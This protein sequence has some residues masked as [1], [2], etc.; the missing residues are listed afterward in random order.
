VEEV[1]AADA[2]DTAEVGGTAA[3]ARRT[4]LDELLEDVDV[5]V[6][7]LGEVEAVRLV[8][9]SEV[10]LVPSRQKGLE[11]VAYL[12]LRMTPVERDDLAYPW[13]FCDEHKPDNWPALIEEY[14][15]AQAV[16]A[17]KEDGASR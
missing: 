13:R 6:R 5:L 15:Y 10:P 4:R 11:A 7:V 3:L 16:R 9:G 8:G 14:A 1:L 2:G 17:L 12:A